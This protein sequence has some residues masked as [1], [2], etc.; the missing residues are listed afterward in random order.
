MLLEDIATAIARK[1]AWTYV[2]P[3]CVTLLV[4][5]EV[6]SR[7]AHTCAQQQGNRLHNCKRGSGAF[8]MRCGV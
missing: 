2:G 6:E 4:Q 1:R 7:N 3:S 5:G 8:R